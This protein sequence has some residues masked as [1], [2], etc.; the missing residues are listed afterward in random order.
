M[1][2]DEAFLMTSLVLIL[3]IFLRR[4][5]RFFQ[6]MRLISRGMERTRRI[7]VIRT[8]QNTRYRHNHKTVW[9][10]PR[11]QFWFE[12]LLLNRYQDH[13]GRE[14]FRVSRDAFQH[15]CGLVGP[16]LMRQNTILREAITVEKRVAV[17]LWRLISYRTVGLT[18]GIG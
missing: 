17:A 3:A 1:A 13:L 11:P 4:R 18:F 15:I 8:I 5:R 2:G 7:V 16:Q 9:V 12:Q 14:H 10:Y 6:K